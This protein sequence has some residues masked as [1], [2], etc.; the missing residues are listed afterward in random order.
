[1]AQFVDLLAGES[2]DRRLAEDQ[3]Q[4]PTWEV[5]VALQHSGTDRGL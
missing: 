2:R 4:A 1:M 5:G 3:N